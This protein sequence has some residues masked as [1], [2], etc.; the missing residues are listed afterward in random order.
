MGTGTGT[1]QWSQS[2]LPKRAALFPN[3]PDEL[4]SAG[5]GQS[6][7]VCV[8]LFCAHQ[9]ADDCQNVPWMGVCQLSLP[10]TLEYSMF[11]Q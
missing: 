6:L 7:L 9:R 11:K 10:Y 5:S 3:P 1:D 4:C 2:L 8:W